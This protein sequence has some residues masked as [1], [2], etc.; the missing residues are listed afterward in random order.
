LRKNKE[1]G[2]EVKKKL[3]RGGRGGYLP[4]LGYGGERLGRKG[5][6]RKGRKRSESRAGDDI[7]SACDSESNNSFRRTARKSVGFPLS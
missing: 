6:R 4:Q 5:D 3:E 2:H 7:R 1:V